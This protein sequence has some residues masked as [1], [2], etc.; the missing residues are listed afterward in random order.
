MWTAACSRPHGAG[1]VP[2]A[3]G[4]QPA[5]G[6]QPAPATNEAVSGI[7][8]PRSRTSRMRRFLGRSWARSIPADHS[9]SRSFLIRAC[10]YPSRRQVGETV[11]PNRQDKGNTRGRHIQLAG[12][13]QISAIGRPIHPTR[14]EANRSSAP[15]LQRHR[16]CDDIGSTRPHHH[17]RAIR[18]RA[19][20][21][22]NWPIQNPLQSCSVR[23]DTSQIVGPHPELAKN[24]LSPWTETD[25]ISP[26]NNLARRRASVQRREENAWLQSAACREYHHAAV[27]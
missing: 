23:L 13:I 5:A 11:R 9:N 18:R 14:T 22:D 10:V 2:P 15:I 24:K 21:V 27:G 8:S 26:L 20:L 16:R 7:G 17:P 1:W 3:A 12:D 19:H 4:R 25:L 6:C